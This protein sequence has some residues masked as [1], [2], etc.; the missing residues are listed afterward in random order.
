MANFNPTG[1]INLNMT[2]TVQ[3]LADQLSL[4][5]KLQNFFNVGGKAGQPMLA[6]AERT[7]QM[8]FIRR[9]AW[10]FN[11]VNLGSGL[12]PL[13]N[14]H[15][16]ISQQGFQDY[17]FAGATCFTLIN[18]TTP[19]GQLPAGGASID[20]MP[21]TYQN[22]LTKVNYGTFLSQSPQSYGFS[23]QANGNLQPAGLV[24]NPSNNTVSVQFIDPHPF[25]LGNIGTSIMLISGSTNPAFNST[26]IYN[27]LSQLSNWINGYLITDI[28]DAFH[29]TLQGNGGQ[30]NTITNITASGGVTTITLGSPNPLPPQPPPIN[31]NPIGP[32]NV[33][34]NGLAGG[35][36]MTFS[37]ITTNS[38]LNGLTVTLLNATTSQVSFTT[39]IGV[40]ITNGA[41]TGTIYAAN[42]GAPGIFNFGW[43][44]AATLFD[45]NN[46]SFPLPVNNID[47]VHRLPPEFDSTGDTITMSCEIDYGCGV[48]KFRLSEPV[49]T[50]PFAFAMVYQAR[51]PKFT[52]GQSIFQW[53][54]D[55]MYVIF[56]VA[57]WQGMRFAYGINAAE[58]TAQMQIASLAIQNAL[59]SEDREA[60]EFT[61]TPNWNIMR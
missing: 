45:I 38:A 31:F 60:N 9:M 17:K 29:V 48:L 23:Q 32:A 52:S 28:P 8:L 6:I 13:E 50:Y 19:G 55:L 40:T 2:T 11:R 5:T 14:P 21:G 34:G 56:E 47:A 24:F 44:E 33:S 22:G 35:Y 57:L 37:G 7:N 39:P 51:A 59:A 4:H 43:L 58:T 36:Q 15:F 20:L 49:S 30:M 12:N 46:P 41:D 61:L 27:Q 25:Q 1:K 26:F 3:A 16:L 18:S 10:K 42:G 54:D 53:P